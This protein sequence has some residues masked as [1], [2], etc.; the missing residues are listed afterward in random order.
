MGPGHANGIPASR[1]DIQASGQWTGALQAG[2]A[3]PAP[4]PR[5]FFVSKTGAGHRERPVSTDTGLCHIHPRGLPQWAHSFRSR[6]QSMHTLSQGVCE[7]TIP[8]PQIV[9]RPVEKAGRTMAFRHRRQSRPSGPCS[10]FSMPRTSGQKRG[11]EGSFLM[12]SEKSRKL[13]SSP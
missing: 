3:E 9:H 10:F 11:E 2:R 13:S 7:E 5:L 12:D 6:A 1:P 4:R 8:S